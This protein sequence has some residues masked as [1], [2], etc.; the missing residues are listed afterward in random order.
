M[1]VC[2]FD[3]ASG[4][5]K[6][7]PYDYIYITAPSEEEAVVEFEDYFGFSPEETTCECCGS[8]YSIYETEE[9]EDGYGFIFIKGG[10]LLQG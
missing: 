7:T 10:D 6:K 1:L 2:F 5:Y 9:I 8:D 3:L 4:G